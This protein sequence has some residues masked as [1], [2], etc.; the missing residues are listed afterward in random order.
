[1][2]NKD[3]KIEDRK[4]KKNVQFI[5]DNAL[6]N[7]IILKSTPKKKDVKANNFAVHGDDIYLRTANGKLLKL[8]ATEIT[9]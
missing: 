3:Y 7:P 2:E 5:Y 6:G 1:M 4:V 9:E 8:T